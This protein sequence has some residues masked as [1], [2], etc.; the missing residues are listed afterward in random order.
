MPR[1]PAEAL[2]VLKPGGG[3]DVGV[4]VTEY[5]FRGYGN[6]HHDYWAFTPTVHPDSCQTPLDHI[7]CH[8][9]EAE[10]HKY[11]CDEKTLA[12]ALKTSEFVAIE[13]RGFDPAV[14]SESRKT[15]TLYMRARKRL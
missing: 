15:S 2:R 8:F 11:A 3:F 5:P 10:K 6:P 13:R 1:F 7:N 9:R 4:Q 12:K 14:N